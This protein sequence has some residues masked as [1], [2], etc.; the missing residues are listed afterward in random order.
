MSGICGWVGEADP[1]SLD[2]MLAAIDYRGDRTDAAF[3][4]GVALGYLDGAFAA[5][6]WDGARR[7][8]TLLRDPF[9]V[10]SLYY[11]EVDGTLYFASELNQLLALPGL[12]VAVDPTA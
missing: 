6:W 2:A 4:P 11:V 8:L 3:A 9:G 5:A 10:R 1:A 7:R 12:P